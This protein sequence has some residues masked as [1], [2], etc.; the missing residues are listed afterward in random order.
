MKMYGCIMFKNYGHFQGRKP[1]LKF[2]HNR[3]GTT[4]HVI[5]MLSVITARDCPLGGKQLECV[6]GD[7][8]IVIS[9]V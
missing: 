7:K 5:V 1:L 2:G 3:L 8:L 4:T 9:L 6:I